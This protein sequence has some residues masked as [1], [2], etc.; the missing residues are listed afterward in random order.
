MS[1]EFINQN[2]TEEQREESRLIRTLE[3]RNPF[4]ILVFNMLGVGDDLDKIY[5][6]SKKISDYIDNPENH[7]VRKLIIQKDFQ[8]AANILVE[9]I[10]KKEALSRAA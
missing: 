7:E 10:K 9:E 5:I 2:M 1:T 8:T 6:Y 4:Q 3:Y